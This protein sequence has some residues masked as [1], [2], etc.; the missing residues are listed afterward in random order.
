MILDR[1]LLQKLGINL[2]FKENSISCG[3]YQADMKDADVTLAEHLAA[4][5]ATTA[6]ATE[7]AKILD[8]K[9]QKV[10]LCTN[11]VEA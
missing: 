6:A 5:E 3:D 2:D 4:V 7:I 11:V 9:Y 1:D 8:A 10:D